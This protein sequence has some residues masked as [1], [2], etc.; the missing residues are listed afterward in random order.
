MMPPFSFAFYTSYTILYIIIKMSS[1]RREDDPVPGSVHG[2]HAPAFAWEAAFAWFV[3]VFAGLV[4]RTADFGVTSMVRALVLSPACYNSLLN[5]FRSSAW[6]T[7]PL[8]QRWREWLMQQEV[9]YRANGR[10]VL[11]GDHTKAPKD[12]RKIPAVRTLPQ[13]LQTPSKST[14]LRGHH[15]GCVALL[16]K[17]AD[18]CFAA[19]LEARIHQGLELFE[20]SDGDQ[21]PKTVRIVQT[22][23]EAVA[24]IGEAAYLLVAY[25]AVGP[26]FKRLPENS[27]VCAVRSTY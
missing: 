24:H 12:G 11:L 1:Q 15:W 13:D 25:F 23:R 26:V 10:L 3:A 17:S 5:F 2:G 6:R 21:L 18:K 20:Q 19:S 9:E 16:L 7:A 27:T 14:F 22:A 8:A 4:L